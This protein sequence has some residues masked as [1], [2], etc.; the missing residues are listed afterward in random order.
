MIKNLPVRLAGGEKSGRNNEVTMLIRWPK[1]G[2][3]LWLEQI[4]LHV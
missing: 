2:V 3:L 4:D 1:C